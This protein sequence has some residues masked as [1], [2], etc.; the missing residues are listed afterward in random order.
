MD[1]RVQKILWYNNEQVIREREE[2]NYFNMT[3]DVTLLRLLEAL[4]KSNEMY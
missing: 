3:D 1:H 4:K 2:Q